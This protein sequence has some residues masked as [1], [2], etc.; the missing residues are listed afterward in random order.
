MNK[1]IAIYLLANLTITTISNVLVEYAD[2]KYWKNG[3]DAPDNLLFRIFIMPQL[4]L[5]EPVSKTYG[6]VMGVWSLFKKSYSID[7]DKR[8]QRNIVIVKGIILMVL[9]TPLFIFGIFS[10]TYWTIYGWY[11]NRKER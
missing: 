7:K 3:K 2:N 5:I 6:Y 11:V 8:F 10:E 9:A 4:F 1:W